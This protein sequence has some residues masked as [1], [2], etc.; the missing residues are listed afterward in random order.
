MFTL[1]QRQLRGDL[2]ETYKIV[3]RK[4]RIDS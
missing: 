2:I 4:E 3:T 1:Q